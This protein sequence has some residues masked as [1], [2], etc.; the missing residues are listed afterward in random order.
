MA[1]PP[2]GPLRR[3]LGALSAALL[4]LAIVVGLTEYVIHV[5]NAAARE[6]QASRM[7]HE[8]SAVRARLEAELNA[9]LHIANGLVGLISAFD[10]IEEARVNRALAVLH[11]HSRHLRNIGLAP[12]NVLR[13]IHPLDG[14]EAAVGVDYRD[15]PSQWPSVRRAMETG[16]TVLDGPVDLI[17]GG[18]GLINRTPVFLED[19][20]YWGVLSL[21]LDIDRL[22]EA[23]HLEAAERR[24]RHVLYAAVDGESR[25]RLI[26]GDPKSLSGGEAV[27][28]HIDV[29][30]GRWTLDVADADGGAATA[31]HANV[32]RTA[33]YIMAAVVALLLYLLLQQR[34]RV[35]FMA[36]HD[37]LT[38]LP[39]RRRFNER[40][41][42]RIARAERR[43]DRFAVL[44]VDLDGFKAIN[45]RFGHQVGDDALVQI[46]G[47][48]RAAMRRDD[49]VAR[50]GGDEFLLM[51]GT[52]DS[53]ARARAFADGL[54]GSIAAPLRDL[55]A[56]ARLGA[57]IGVAL[58]P[59]DG[60][61]GEQ[62]R[63]A[64][65]TDMYA[66]KRRPPG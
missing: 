44:Y 37:Q 28:M 47:R 54:L 58:Y 18:R 38:G 4:L 8:A 41:R 26:A 12:D 34:N 49:A 36:M 25:G 35:A 16:D 62:L 66:G 6:A 9:T 53:R 20:S 60:I 27:S 21:V 3:R 65:D 61:S 30:G 59:D 31:L 51:L 14:N 42:Q 39:N 63:H 15:V 24:I 52:V 48:I 56:D 40:L 29:P 64:A 50:V 33:G 32:Q 22:L 5:E 7:L 46:A 55:P 2:A 43:H 11:R 45:D 13:Y 17:Q 23:V 10:F 1:E 19:G 57:S